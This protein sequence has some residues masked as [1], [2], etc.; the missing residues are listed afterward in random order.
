MLEEIGKIVE[1]ET[2]EKEKP[3]LGASQLASFLKNKQEKTNA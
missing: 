1:L 3:K 2:K